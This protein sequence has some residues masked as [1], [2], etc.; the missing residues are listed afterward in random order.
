MSCRSPGL[1]ALLP[2]LL[3]LAGCGQGPV[4]YVDPPQADAGPASDSGRVLAPDGGDGGGGGEGEDDGIRDGEVGEREDADNRES[5]DEESEEQEHCEDLDCGVACMDDADCV[6]E[7]DEWRC[8]PQGHCVEC[9]QDAD[10]AG[11]ETCDL[12]EGECEE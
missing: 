11:S 8:A 2:F 9:L 12:E 1:G 10:C 3:A 6:A 4:I 7:E 5:D